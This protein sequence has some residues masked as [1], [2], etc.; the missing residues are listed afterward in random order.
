MDKSTK[1]YLWLLCV[2]LDW[3]L[4]VI[5]T[6]EHLFMGPI[7]FI[8]LSAHK[9]KTYQ[10]FRKTKRHFCPLVSVMLREQYWKLNSYL[11]I[12]DLTIET[13]WK[14]CENLYCSIIS[15]LDFFSYFWESNRPGPLKCFSAPHHQISA[16]SAPQKARNHDTAEFATKKNVNQVNSTKIPKIKRGT[17]ESHS[18]FEGGAYGQ[19]LKWFIGRIWLFHPINLRD[20]DICLTCDKSTY[21]QWWHIWLGVIYHQSNEPLK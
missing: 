21:H 14:I 1:L 11:A 7:K 15:C 9:S 3:I 18:L 12:C 10:I 19:I 8:E 16:K 17:F 2:W 4:F 6:K 13:E 20:C 5:V